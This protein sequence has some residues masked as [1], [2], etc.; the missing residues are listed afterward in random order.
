MNPLV[1]DEGDSNVSIGLNNILAKEIYS[2]VSHE[3][4]SSCRFHNNVY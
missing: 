3:T 1:Q 4:L 2:V